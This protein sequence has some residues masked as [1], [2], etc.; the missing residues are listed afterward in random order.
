MDNSQLLEDVPIEMRIDFWIVLARW[1]HG[2]SP[3]RW[4]K[5]PSFMQLWSKEPVIS[6]KKTI[7]N[8]ICRVY[9]PSYNQL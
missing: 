4:I 7:E 1:V 3:S 9:K 6:T 8:P 2:E 5:I